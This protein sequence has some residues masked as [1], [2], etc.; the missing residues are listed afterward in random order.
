MTCQKNN[1]NY[2]VLE[3]LYRD[4][5]NYKAYGKILLQGAC[6]CNQEWEIMESCESSIYFIAEQVG[7]PSLYELLYEY[8]GGP[9]EDDHV[10]HEF[11]S[12]RQA[13]KDDLTMP[14][15]GELDELVQ[16]F[17]AAKEKWKYNLSPHWYCA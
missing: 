17:G 13:S 3:Y 14:C 6:E 5:S 8:S 1:S 9:T 4:A 2:S 15:W 12:L 11:L 10:F 7:L 16:K